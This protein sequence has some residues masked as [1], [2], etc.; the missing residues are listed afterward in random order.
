MQ[1]EAEIEYLKKQKEQLAEEQQQDEV[2]M[3]T[4]TG[5]PFQAIDGDGDKEK[6]V[7]QSEV[8]I[9]YLKKQVD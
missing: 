5:E 9:E 4:L 8:E 3:E 6:Q 7:M 2:V 1:S